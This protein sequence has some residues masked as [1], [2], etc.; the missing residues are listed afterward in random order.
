[1]DYYVGLI[2]RE[3]DDYPNKAQF[4]NENNLVIKELE[5]DSE[6]RRFI[7]SEVTFTDEEKKQFR[8]EELEQ[9]LKDT[10][11][12]SIKLAELR[13]SGSSAFDGEYAR[14]QTILEQRKDW[15]TELNSLKG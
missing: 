2:F 13:Y 10:D 4:C 1:M 9:K 7:I 3:D 6:G 14:Y 8:I 15:R 12:V 5:P 11:Y